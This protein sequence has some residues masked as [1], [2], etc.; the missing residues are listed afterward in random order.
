MKL[1]CLQSLELGAYLNEGRFLHEP[2]LAFRKASRPS[3]RRSEA[4]GKGQNVACHRFAIT[5]SPLRI[6]LRDYCRAGVDNPS[7]NLPCSS[8]AKAE[9]SVP[10]HI[11][12]I[13]MPYS[14]IK[15]LVKHAY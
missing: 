6:L 3:Q 13:R 9:D 2:P 12:R 1:G 8:L 7:C 10:I 14:A 11:S 5:K 15:I 4:G